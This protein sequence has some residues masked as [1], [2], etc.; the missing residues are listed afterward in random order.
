[1]QQLLG[2]ADDVRNFGVSGTT[3]LKHGDS[4]YWKTKA[5]AAALAFTPDIV[6]IDLGGNDS[7][8]QNWRFKAEF[9]G[10]AKAL[11]ASFRNLPTQPRILL[12]LPMP[13]FQVMWG[14][15]EQVYTNDL[16]PMLRD[17]A[18]ETQ[19][20]LV[21]LHTPFLDKGAWFADHI[22]PNAEGAALMAKIIGEAITVGATPKLPGV[23]AAM[24]A[25]I[26]AREIA[27]AVTVVVTK[28]KILPC[29]TTGL[30]NLAKKEPMRPDSLFWIASMTKPITA[31]ARADAAG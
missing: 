17:V 30:A 5:Y 24:E 6:V 28:D 16:I 22:H 10:D 7:K 15:N 14:I 21:D 26:E 8:P 1:M 31:V 13:A 23:G 25:A 29:E 3:M 4:P 11:I 27:G 9:T 18:R 2:A 19:S 12:C 20:E